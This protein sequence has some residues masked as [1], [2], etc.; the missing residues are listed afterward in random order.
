MKTKFI[1][2][3]WTHIPAILAL[4]AG[5]AFTLMALP[6]PGGPISNILWRGSSVF[7]IIKGDHF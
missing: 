1:H 5:I 4:L 6:L 3:L 7:G 2:P